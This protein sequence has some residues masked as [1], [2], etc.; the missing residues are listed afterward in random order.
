MRVPNLQR[1]MASSIPLSP[2]CLIERSA[3]LKISSIPAARMRL[4]VGPAR[5]NRTFSRF[6]G[7]APNF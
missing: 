7:S 5:R 2:R 1:S 6:L 3:M 4:S